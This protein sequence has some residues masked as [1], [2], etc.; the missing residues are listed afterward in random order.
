MSAFLPK[1]ALAEKGGSMP[2]W[3]V[4]NTHILTMWGAGY[5]RA[6]RSA[7]MVGSACWWSIYICC[8]APQPTIVLLRNRPTIVSH[9][10]CIV[11]FV[12]NPRTVAVHREKPAYFV[13]YLLLMYCTVLYC[14][15]LYCTVLY[16]SILYCTS[17]YCTVLQC[18]FG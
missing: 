12:M 2:R 13:F 17:V 9:L 14:T 6:R 10:R 16:F 11:F 18:S 5:F 7:T 15:V 4:G 3:L 1:K 8:V